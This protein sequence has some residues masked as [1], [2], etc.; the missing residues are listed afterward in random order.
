M[1]VIVDDVERDAPLRARGPVRIQS[2]PIRGSGPGIRR[3]R[4]ASSNQDLGGFAPVSPI[5]HPVQHRRSPHG[6][7]HSD[8]LQFQGRQ[9]SLDRLQRGSEYGSPASRTTS[10]PYERS[11]SV[12]QVHPHVY[13]LNAPRADHVCSSAPVIPDG[14]EKEA[15]LRTNLTFAFFHQSCHAGQTGLLRRLAGRDGQIA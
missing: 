9:R 12:D 5:V 2:G 13:A 8:P 4:R 15:S 14:V 1:P 11:H 6:G 7:E 3:T 10:A